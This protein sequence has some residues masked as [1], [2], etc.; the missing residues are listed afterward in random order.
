MKKWI[1][2]AAL[3]GALYYY[4][5]HTESGKKQFQQFVN[6]FEQW[7]GQDVTGL[8]PANSEN[9]TTIYKIQNPDGSWTYSNEKPQ[10]DT[11]AEKQQYRADTNV[12]PSIDEADRGEKQTDKE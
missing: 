4:A 10:D 8:G 3:F 12:L 2:V 7:T 11:L 9:Q 1:I 5:G 6:H